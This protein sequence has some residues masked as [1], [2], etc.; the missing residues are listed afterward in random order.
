MANIDYFLSYFNRQKEVSTAFNFKNVAR[1]TDLLE[2]KRVKGKRIFVIGNGGSACNAS[3]FATDL[4]KGASDNVENTNVL[5]RRFRVC[6]LT[7]NVSWI[8]ALGNDYNYDRVFVDQLKTVAVQG[9]VLIGISVS[10]TSPNLVRAFEYA[11]INDIHTVALV[12]KKAHER[13]SIV[14][15][16]DIVITV[17][18]T[19]YGAVEDAQMN[20]LHSVC[21][22][23]ME[24][25]FNYPN[26]RK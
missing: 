15:Y 26:E 16:S 8:T 7:D 18:E 19:H 23:F 14:N 22:Y 11:N 5:S 13:H 9:D 24:N 25:G 2:E 6:S 1:L 10:G 4:G 3:H 17:E 12:G 21:Y 20:I